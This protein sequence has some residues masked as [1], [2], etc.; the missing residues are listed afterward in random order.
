MPDSHTLLPR[1]PLT[2]FKRVSR[3]LKTTM[4]QTLEPVVPWFPDLVTNLFPSLGRVSTW[5]PNGMKIRLI[6]DGPDGKDYIARKVAGRKLALYET[7]TMRV[8]LTLLEHSRTFI[9]I[10]ANTGLFALAAAVSAPD[11]RVFAFEPVPQIVQRLRA[12]AQLNRLANLSVEPFA[13]SDSLG[14]ITFHVPATTASLPSSSSAAAGFKA[15]TQAI[16]VP[17]ITLDAF[18]ESRQ[19]AAIDLM[20]I[21]TETTEHLVLAGAAERIRRDQPAIICEVLY[22][23]DEQPI[24][25]ILNTLMRPLGYR[26]F[27]ITDEGLV[28]TSAPL[29]DPRVILHNYLFIPPHRLDEVKPLIVPAHSRLAA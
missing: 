11:R 13:A 6:S 2:G 27:W 22:R 26:Y 23:A 18:A 29:G 25:R 28:E 12:N 4:R 24:Q 3:A 5:L 21:D 8:F 16:T 19:I 1:K 20:K 10:G 14:E 17:A 9:D 15:H 7:E